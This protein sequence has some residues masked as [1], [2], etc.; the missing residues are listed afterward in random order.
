MS[1]KLS[2]ETERTI[3]QIKIVALGDSLTFGFPYSPSYSWVHLVQESLCVPF[4]NKGING[5]TT[6][7]MLRRFGRD[8]L[9]NNPSHV[10]ITGGTNDSCTPVAA[11]KVLGNIAAMTEMAF[12]NGI[13]PIIGLP[14]PLV[15]S[16]DEKMLAPYREAMKDFAAEKSINTINFYQAFIDGNGSV[17][18]N[19]FEDG[20]H[21]NLA[22]YKAMAAIAL[23]SLKEL[24]NL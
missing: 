3:N 18:T 21:P 17:Q 11:D 13:I 10:I 19:L 24:L 23:Y 7:D 1:I 15:F 5:D 22:G 16:Y 4:Y 8:C 20:A 14:P 2:D 6:S 9:D 12:K